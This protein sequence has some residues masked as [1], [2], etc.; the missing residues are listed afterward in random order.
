MAKLPILRFGGLEGS[1]EGEAV[2][3]DVTR[4]LEASMRDSFTK[5][6]GASR[7]PPALKMD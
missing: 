2:A 4:R 6:A 3:K 1:V 5:A 7:Y